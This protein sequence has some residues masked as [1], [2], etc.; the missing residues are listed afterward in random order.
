M[1]KLLIYYKNRK[2]REKILIN[3]LIV[4]IVTIVALSTIVTTVSSNSVEELA[5]NNTLQLI[6][7]VNNNIE[8]YIN[9]IEDI[10]YYI[11]SDKDVNEFLFKGKSNSNEK[12]IIELLTLYEKANREIA[13]MMIVNLEDEFISDYMERVSRDPL[14]NEK[15]YV[16]ATGNPK[17]IQILSNT[18]GRNIR[19]KDNVYSG[20]DVVTISKAILNEKEEIIGVILIDLKLIVI[21]EAIDDVVVGKSGFV[22]V[23]NKDNRIVYSPVN[24][25][26]YRIQPKWLKGNSRSRQ[27]DIKN[28]KYKIMWHDSSYT[29]WKIVGVFSLK[30]TL[31]AVN[32]I[33]IIIIIFSIGVVVLSFFIS[34]YLSNTITKPIGE[35][36]NLMQRAEEGQLEVKFNREYDDEIGHL[37]RRFNKMI[38]AVKNL[39]NL[40][41]IE[42]QKKKEAELEIFRAQIKPHFLYNTLDTIHWLI[43]ENNNLEAGIVLKALTTLFRISLSKGKEQIEIKEELKHVESYITI[44]K[45]RYGDKFDYEINCTKDIMELKITKLILQPIVE[46]ALYHGI[47]EKRGKG[48]IKIDI[49]KEGDEILLYVIDDG[50]GISEK[51]TDRLNKVLSKNI[52][53]ENEY[54]L[55]NVNEK[56]K[57]TYGNQYGVIIE[58]KE[59]EGTKVIIKHPM[60]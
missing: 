27:I 9:N 16:Q 31:Y 15:W 36:E 5:D 43:K 3:Y 33:K 52:E 20:D 44:Q 12:D 49:T 50:I 60:I 26:V 39:I 45:V 57:L 25:I 32:N 24:D 8:F 48:F 23:Q 46:N 47:K 30:D 1:N 42:Q 28:V 22:Y 34:F 35:L 4:I 37:G 10:I 38:E 17:H 21:E 58:S 7:Q 29:G 59:G 41:N 40:V 53:K 13:G 19:Y 14:K 18:I 54:G 6:K 55:V 2:L 56:I 51:E 11:S